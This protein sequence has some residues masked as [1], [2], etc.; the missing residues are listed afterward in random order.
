MAEDGLKL[1]TDPELH[2]RVAAQSRR[3]VRKRFCRDLIVP[4]Y[5]NFYKE[6]L[7]HP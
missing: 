4:Q 1:L 6:I 5:E 2:G 7:G 3:L